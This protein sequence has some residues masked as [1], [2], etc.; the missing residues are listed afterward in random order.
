MVSNVRYA[1][2]IFDGHAV[3]EARDG[4][5][6]Y[7]ADVSQIVLLCHLCQTI[8]V[9]CTTRLPPKN[10]CDKHVTCD[11]AFHSAM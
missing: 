9:E 8:L 6:R 11:T 2:Y 3:N 7:R 4:P 1:P 5:L 10:T